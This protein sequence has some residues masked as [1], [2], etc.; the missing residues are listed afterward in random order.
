MTNST[1]TTTEIP[2]DI[3]R[4]H[5]LVTTSSYVIAPIGIIFNILAL[6]VW[7]IIR[8]QTTIYPLL[9]ILSFC[10]CISL[11][12]SLYAKNYQQTFEM[13]YSLPQKYTVQFIE[14]PDSYFH[15]Q[16]IDAKFVVRFIRLTMEYMSFLTTLAI[17]ITRFV[18]ISRPLKAKT[19][20]SVNLCVWLGLVSLIISVICK[21][22]ITFSGAVFFPS[23]EKWTIAVRCIIVFFYGLP[24]FVMLVVNAGMLIHLCRMRRAAR[25]LNSN[26]DDTGNKMTVT[27]SLMTLCSLLVFPVR[28]ISLAYVVSVPVSGNIVMQPGSQYTAA[29]LIIDNITGP[30]EVASRINS[31]VNLLFYCTLGTRFK[32]VLFGLGRRT[33]DSKPKS[34]PER[35]SQHVSTII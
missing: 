25:S 31:S 34:K 28:A 22:A 5:D 23:V 6:I 15:Y 10:D 19:F 8:K 21:L 4:F 20:I 24:W 32:N 1:S 17:G 3:E 26:Q 33:E 35:L 16:G 27:V 30:T 18:A 14:F 11:V 7:V 9:V 29:K 12:C 2:N 13:F